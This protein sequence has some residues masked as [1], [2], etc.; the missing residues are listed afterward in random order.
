M[1]SIVIA[2][3]NLDGNSFAGVE[4]TSV[5]ITPGTVPEFPAGLLV[6]ITIGFLAVIVFSR[7]SIVKN[8]F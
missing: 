5:V 7:R 2:F 6:V 1:E 8:H 4:F 3:E